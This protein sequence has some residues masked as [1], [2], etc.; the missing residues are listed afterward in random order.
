[1]STAT[2]LITEMLAKEH[3]DVTYMK[4]EGIS[5]VLSKSLM[6]TY[7]TK[8]KDPIEFFAKTLLG[9]AHTSKAR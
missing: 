7:L 2:H 8:P 1:M 4:Q 9:H 6:Q 5:L 3:P